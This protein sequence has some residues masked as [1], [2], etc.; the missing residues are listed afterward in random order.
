MTRVYISNARPEECSELRLILQN[1]NMEVVGES[2]NWFTTVVEVPVSH[3]EMLLVD[4]DLLPINSPGAALSGLR[5]ACP[6]ALV[7]IF[8]SQQDIKKQAA[9]SISADMFITR[10]ETAKH[11]AER[12]QAVAASIPA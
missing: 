9:L 6:S 12:L 7:V 2:A 11:L 1:L 8:I 4:W 10:G 3:V 5:K